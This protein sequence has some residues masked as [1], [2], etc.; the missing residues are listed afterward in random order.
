MIKTMEGKSIELAVYDKSE[1]FPYMEMLDNM[2]VNDITEEMCRIVKDHNP[3][4]DL[5]PFSL[6]PFTVRVVECYIK[7]LNR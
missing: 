6:D 3:K 5:D 7:L 4:G 1:I 2:P